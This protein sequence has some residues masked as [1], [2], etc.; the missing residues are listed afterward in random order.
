MLRKSGQEIYR[1]SYRRATPVFK[2]ALRVLSTEG[3]TGKLVEL[4]TKDEYLNFSR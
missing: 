2:N 4:K 3:E 1:Q